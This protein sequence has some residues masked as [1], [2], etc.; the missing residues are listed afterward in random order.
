M[1]AA[2]AMMIEAIRCEAAYISYG[3]RFVY[4]DTGDG[5]ERSHRLLPPLA[6][7]CRRILQAGCLKFS[8]RCSVNAAGSPKRVAAAAA[9]V[10][11]AFLAS[12][13]TVFQHQ[14]LRSIHAPNTIFTAAD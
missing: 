1:Q 12:H 6:G 4:D 8:L 9:I 7:A 11:Y 5:A 14:T 2:A 13:A 10:V 3:R